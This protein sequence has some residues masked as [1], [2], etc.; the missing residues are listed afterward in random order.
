VEKVAGQRDDLDLGREVGIAYV[1]G[2][3]LLGQK[4][5]M[6]QIGRRIAAVKKRGFQNGVL[7]EGL[8]DARREYLP[9]GLLLQ[10]TTAAYMVGV[11]VG[12][13]YAAQNPAVGVQYLTNLSAGILIA[14][15]VYEIHAVP[16]GNVYADLGRTVYIITFFSGFFELVHDRALFLYFCRLYHV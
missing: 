7:G 3:A 2:V 6:P 13:K 12:N 1:H 5:F 16:A 4:K 8:L 14:A 11:G 10:I 9:A 15:A